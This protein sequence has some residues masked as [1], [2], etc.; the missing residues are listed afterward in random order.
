MKVFASEF[1]HDRVYLN[2][3]SFD[4]MFYQCSRGSAD[5][6]TTVEQINKKTFTTKC[7]ELLT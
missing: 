4:A 1:V 5:S 2:N 7:M 3:S 6:K